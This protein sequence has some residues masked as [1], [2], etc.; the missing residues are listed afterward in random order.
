MWRGNLY[1]MFYPFLYTQRA[2]TCMF[3]C[4]SLVLSLL[5]IRIIIEE[6]GTPFIHRFDVNMESVYLQFF[7]LVVCQ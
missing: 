4:S 6:T 5:L 7:I 3:P 1:Y 2:W